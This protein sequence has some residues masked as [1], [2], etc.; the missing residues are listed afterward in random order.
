MIW[1]E[2]SRASEK[3]P[4]WPA[5]IIHGA[6]II[7]EEAGELMRAAVQYE[8]EGGKRDE[9][10]KEAIQVAAT[11]IR[12]LQSSRIPLDSDRVLMTH[13]GIVTTLN[14]LSQL[15]MYPAISRLDKGT[16]FIT[17]A[18]MV[19]TSSADIISFCIHH[20]KDGLVRNTV[21][22]TASVAMLVIAA[23]NEGPMLQEFPRP[24]PPNIK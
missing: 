11:C 20:P 1:Q 6:S 10:K 4:S 5:D 8:R 9:I 16:D 24:T 13:R 23:V 22:T 19:Y 15:P 14:A 17:K 7:C 2:V 3:H 21:L 18:S 12:F